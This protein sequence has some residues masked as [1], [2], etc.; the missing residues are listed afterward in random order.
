M[1][2]KIVLN[3]DKVMSL[4]E[5]SWDDVPDIRV[6]EPTYDAMHKK[7]VQFRLR[8]KKAYRK[9]VFKYHP[10]H[11]GDP[12]MMKQ[13]NEIY[14]IVMNQIKI[15]VPQPRPTFTMR[16]YGYGDATSSTTS[17]SSTTWW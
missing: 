13:I 14:D 10:D 2:H 12:E 11:G 9:I 15:Q 6:P 1:Q 5:L 8:F 16:V 4:F 3:M 7:L 17:T